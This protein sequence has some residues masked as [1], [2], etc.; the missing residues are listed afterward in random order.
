MQMQKKK[1]RISR[2]SDGEIGSLITQNIEM[3]N[4]DWDKDGISNDLEINGYKIEFNSQT[5]KK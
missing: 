2:S 1:I 3:A 4:N 5:G